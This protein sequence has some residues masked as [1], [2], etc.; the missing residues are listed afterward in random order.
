MLCGALPHM[1]SQIP[2]LFDRSFPCSLH[3]PH[4]QRALTKA[5]QAILT[6]I[7]MGLP[8]QAHLAHSM[9]ASVP[10]RSDPERRLW[11]GVD[12]KALFWKGHLQ[13]HMYTVQCGHLL[14]AD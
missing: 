8:C 1:A 11:G 10:G 14:T 7:I 13:F 2:F 9:E 6:L 3:S 4:M 12:A 5:K